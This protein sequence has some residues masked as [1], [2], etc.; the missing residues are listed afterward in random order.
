ME[1]DDARVEG[2]KEEGDVVEDRSGREEEVKERV[3][4]NG[5]TENDKGGVPKEDEEA[6]IS[7]RGREKAGMGKGDDGTEDEPVS[8]R[9]ERE[10]GP[11]YSVEVCSHRLRRRLRANTIS[12]SD[13]VAPRGEMTA[14]GGGEGAMEEGK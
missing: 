1:D 7:D 5:G 6:V 2:E 12:F 3:R 8:A 9:R 11:W 13:K 14:A 10:P 4:P